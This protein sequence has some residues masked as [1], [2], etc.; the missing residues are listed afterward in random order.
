[1]RRA[2]LPAAAPTA[3]EPNPP[4]WGASVH[5]FSPRARPEAIA[6]AVRA[7]FAQNGGTVPQNHG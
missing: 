4:L 3:A 7:A 2:L 6:A 1:M 5:V